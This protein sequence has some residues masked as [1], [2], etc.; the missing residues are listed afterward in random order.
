M[1]KAK[2]RHLALCARDR[3]FAEYR[4][5]DPEGNGFDPSEHGFADPETADRRAERA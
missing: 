2:I 1:S 3:P 5:V 4:A